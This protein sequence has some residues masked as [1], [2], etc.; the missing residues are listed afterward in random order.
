MDNMEMPRVIDVLLFDGVNILDV[1]GPV[2]AF[3]VATGRQGKKAYSHR[4]VS[5]DGQSVKAS[6][7]LTMGC[8][9]RL[10]AGARETDL[11]VPGGDVAPS[12]R[13]P[14]LL[15]IIRQ[16]FDAGNN[17]RLISICSGALILAASG[18]LDGCEATSHWS[19]AQQV[20]VEFPTVRWNFDRIFTLSDRIYTSAG[21]SSGIDLALAMI[22]NDLG[23]LAARAVAQELVVYLRRT[24]GQSQFSELLQA[25][26][27]TDETLTQLIDRIVNEPGHPWQLEDLA[28]AAHMTPRTLS[29]KFHKAF[30]TPPVHY[31]EKIR[32]ARARSLLD[33]NVPLKTVAGLCGFGDVQRMRRGFKR[34][35]G[36]G[37]A[38]YVAHFS[39]SIH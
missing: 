5:M 3:D 23:S 12:M 2:Q 30:G 14:A 18:V 36:V 13:N 33:E 29:R 16:R 4:F 26:F 15:D 37:L 22:G 32:V 28:A 31:V 20:A 8:D 10:S 35:L 11:I 9:A 1:A 21:V 34:Q 25:Q 39:P 27:T 17:S 24:G 38:D 7:G 6:C 19:R